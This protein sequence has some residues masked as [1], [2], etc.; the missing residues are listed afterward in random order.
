MTYYQGSYYGEVVLLYCAIV[1][2]HTIP[3]YKTH[4]SI[5]PCT[6]YVQCRKFSTATLPKFTLAQTSSNAS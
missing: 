5:V 6:V 1:Q 3:I 2:Y 4:T